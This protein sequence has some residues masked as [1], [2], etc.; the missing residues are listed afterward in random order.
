[1]VVDRQDG[2]VARHV[3]GDLD[4][5]AG[6][7]LDGVGEQVGDHLVEAARIPGADRPFQAPDVEHAAASQRLVAQ[8]RPDLA[9][10]RHQIDLFDLQL[11]PA[12]RD[13]RHVEEL[14][15]EVIEPRCL[16]V[17]PLR[18]LSD[19]PG[20][21]ADAAAGKSQQVLH[22]QPQRGERRAELVRGDREKVLAQADRLAQHLLGLLLV[23]DVGRGSD[24][25]RNCAVAVAPP[26]G[27]HARQMPA[28]GSVGGPAEPD[29]SLEGLLPGEALLEGLTDAGAIVRVKRAPERFARHDPRLMAEVVEAGAVPERDAALHVGGPDALWHHVQE[30]AVALLAGPQQ[31]VALVFAQQLAPAP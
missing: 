7:V 10:H 6:P 22:L 25:A 23:V 4:R 14:V 18:A 19:G 12:G 15:D 31:R 29:L 13:A 2:A 1:M 21:F 5:L 8:A 20:G 30:V 11:Q 24:P 27:H 9:D 17:D 16:G 28:V 26:L 3:D